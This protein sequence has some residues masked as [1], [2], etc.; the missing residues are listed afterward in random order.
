MSDPSGAATPRLVVAAAA[1]AACRAL[2]LERDLPI[3]DGIDPATL[4]EVVLDPSVPAHEQL[5]LALER[6]IDPTRRRASGSYFTPA[7]LAAHLTGLA[8]NGRSPSEV[9]TVVDPAVG[10]GAFLL[11]AAQ[12]LAAA[13]VD[14]AEVVTHRLGGVDLDPLAALTA[15]SSLLVWARA[16]GARVAGTGVAV[17]DGLALD[18]GTA[19]AVLGN[20]PFQSQ[21]GRLT[22]RGAEG[23][24]ALRA[25]FGD[26]VA[27]Y[28]DT[29]ALFLLA[30]CRL[31]REGGVVCLVLPQS[32][33]GAR[34]ARG[35]RAAVASA[36]RVEAIWLGDRSF[37][38]A[39]VRVCAP[40]V[41]VGAAPR[42]RPVVRHQGLGDDASDAPATVSE[43][44]LVGRASWSVLLADRS[45]VP[46]VDLS[47]GGGD[48][49]R[50]GDR[51]HPT[52]GFRDEYY[53]IAGLVEEAPRGLPD[54]GPGSARLI[55]CGLVE[56]MRSR[57]GAH[58]A[59][60]HRR[61]WDR[62]RVLHGSLD[63][64]GRVGRWAR[65]VLVPKVIVATQT[66]VLEGIVDVDG[67]CWPA[68]PTIAVAAP[69][70]DLWH[71]AAL[72][73]APPVSAWMWARRAGTALGERDLGVGERSRR[74]PAPAARR[75]RA[76]ALGPRRGGRP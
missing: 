23:G 51:W 18:P 60:V 21:L 14:P 47:C 10:G 3:L 57:W 7:P 41:G 20:P 26:A 12:W 39:G 27:A 52:A 49:P 22:A 29:A 17:G 11:A 71:L 30:A 8:L 13:G 68:V 62:P 33:L 25:R 69:P 19:D 50:L 64:E 31:A 4:P 66:K 15:S 16:R 45:S 38:D 53:G 43:S 37:A 2:H 6:S 32:V 59:T 54:V 40:V 1:L 36:G 72:V 5:G 24:E 67:T 70:V 56:P 65:S 35:V 42:A 44:E 28:T 55:T 48:G 75:R 73:H 46:P 9:G 58:R 63:P 34:D 74:G 61:R 76:R